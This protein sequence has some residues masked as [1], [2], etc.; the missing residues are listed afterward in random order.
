MPNN[1]RSRT[2]GR[3]PLDDISNVDVELFGQDFID[4]VMRE[5]DS[6]S[7]DSHGPSEL[8]ETDYD[9]NVEHGDNSG[10]DENPIASDSNSDTENDDINSNDVELDTLDLEGLIHD[11]NEEVDEKGEDETPNV[12]GLFDGNQQNGENSLQSG[13]DGDGG[14]MLSLGN[15]DLITAEGS[16]SHGPQGD[17]PVN[18]DDSFTLGGAKSSASESISS[19][20]RERNPHNVVVGKLDDDTDLVNMPDWADS[21]RRKVNANVAHSFLLSGNV[22]DYMVRNVSL[23]DGLV[24][25]L[26]SDGDDFDVIACYDQ[27]NGISFYDGKSRGLARRNPSEYKKRFIQEMNE[28]QKRLALPVTDDIPQRDPVLLFSIIQDM[29]ENP[30]HDKKGKILLFVD[31]I[32][33]LVPDAS[34]AQMK[35]DERKL[36]IILSNIGRSEKADVNNSIMIMLSDD[37][38]QLSSRLKSS[39]SRIEKVKIPIPDNDERLDFIRNILDVNDN[40]LSDGT[41]LFSHPRSISQEVFAVNSAGLSRRQIEDITLRALSDDVPLTIQLM[42]DRK[43]EIIKED[44]DD[45][46]EVVDPKFGFERVGG[47]EHIKRLFQEEVIDPIHAGEK[48]AVPMGI[49]LSGNPGSGKT[50]IAKALAKESNMNFVALNLN[51]IMDKWVGSSERNLE[52]AL[53]CAIAMAPTIIFIDEIDEALPNRNAD[54]QSAVNKRINQRLLTF[55]SET[56][57]RGDVMILAAT[58]YPS[59]ID[60]AFKRAGRFDIRI[61][62]FAPNEY[63]RMRIMQ[64]IARSRGYSFSWFDSPD[65]M[66]ENPFKGLDEWIRLGNSPAS[67][68]GF[69]GK[70]ASYSYVVDGS[71]GG[72][73]KHEVFLPKKLIRI[74]GKNQITLEQLYE[75]IGILFDDLPTRKPDPS[76]GEVE[77][78]KRFMMRLADYLSEKREIIGNDLENEKRLLAYIWRWEMIYKPFANQTF[79]M[80]GAEL[81]VVMNK[82][83]T[84]YKRW[85]RKIG[86]SEVQ[87]YVD[88]G[89]IQNDRDI[90]WNPFL[91]EAC[92]RTVNATAGIKE[93]EDD[94]LLNTSDTDF[95]P[96]ALYGVTDDGRAVSYEERHEELINKEQ[97]QGI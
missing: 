18:D 72:S 57:H 42:K 4:Q 40:V 85:K 61:P 93:M 46:L 8:A 87:K 34:S 28:S 33:L 43:S 78:D 58:N 14:L 24:T 53:D 37:V 23:I 65:K 31:Y 1:S 44:Y 95:I 54:N 79:M 70:K 30:S 88:S 10:F 21:I 74:L 22:R 90:P 48:E 35:P 62:M 50:M 17:D 56:E 77:P 73:E 96:D 36:S 82:A 51:R 83:I 47:L 27:S 68:N 39:E 13:H 25:I 7:R 19:G 38:T 49:L 86:P 80:T 15:D 76:T 92:Q 6:D 63:D 5:V 60:P 66:V 29:F 67:N 41:Q 89:A 12:D 16:S 2:K 52:R 45:V 97:H 11:I 64:V 71:N 91:L 81:D 94:A 84:L 55:F 69:S 59:K 9:D 75:N 32:D 20:L 3:S 26:N